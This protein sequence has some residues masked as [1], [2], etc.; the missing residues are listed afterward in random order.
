MKSLPF[1]QRRVHVP[2]LPDQE[3][4]GSLLIDFLKH[5]LS[6]LG[7]PR[8]LVL[9]NKVCIKP[10]PIIDLSVGSIL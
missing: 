5:G 10:E 3:E 6:P 4:G 9:A 2:K 8:S 7:G 1:S